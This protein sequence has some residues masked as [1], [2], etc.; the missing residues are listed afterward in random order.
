M[1]FSYQINSHKSDGGIYPVFPVH[2]IWR[3][4]VVPLD[5]EFCDEADFRTLKDNEK[6]NALGE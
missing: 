5:A 6:N 3:K 1:V 2:F 4:L